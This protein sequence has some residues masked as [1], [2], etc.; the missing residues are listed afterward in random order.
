MEGKK[1]ASLST[2]KLFIEN[3]NFCILIL[4]LESKFQDVSVKNS[5]VIINK[6]WNL[7][8]VLIFSA[9]RDV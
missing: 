6:K 4:H 7:C 1:R 3:M 8:V 9:R 2:R 5:T